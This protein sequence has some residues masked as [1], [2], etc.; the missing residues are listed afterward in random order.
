MTPESYPA[1]EADGVAGTATDGVATRE[2]LAADL[3]A[4]DP[5]MGVAARELIITHHS[6]F[7]HAT[8]LAE[9]L[10]RLAPEAS[11]GPGDA[12]GELARLARRQWESERWGA[13]NVSHMVSRV[14][15]LRA[16]IDV[17]G[18]ELE[19]ERRETQTVRRDAHERSQE[20]RRA[21]DELTRLWD[22]THA[23]EA[24][25]ER[26]R[27]LRRHRVLARLLAPVDRL[28]GRVRR[29]R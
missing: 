18:A 26:V 22:R 10:Q 20:L 27:G 17:L 16:R 5:A 6:P 1:I 29:R 25:L 9:V 14:E 24:E 13:D 23:A 12:A 21:A 7:A 15:E 19:T 8:A 4:Y 28:R 3:T 11:E 2:R